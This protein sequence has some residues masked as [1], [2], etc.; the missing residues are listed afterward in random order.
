MSKSTSD[1]RDTLKEILFSLKGIFGRYTRS[2]RKEAWR[3]LESAK[4]KAEVNKLLNNPNHPIV[5]VPRIL[6]FK[7]WL[8]HKA[9][10]H[11]S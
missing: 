11:D 7:E 1:P 10:R 2:A 9:E 8:Q 6:D 4:G 5:G 3:G